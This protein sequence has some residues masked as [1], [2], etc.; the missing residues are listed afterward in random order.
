MI[1]SRT[2]YVTSRYLVKIEIQAKVDWPASR[3]DTTLLPKAQSG[4]S[5]RGHL[6]HLFIV[7]I[8]LYMFVIFACLLE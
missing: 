8:Y 2:L 3:R 6:N 4:L 1:P 5:E 7:S